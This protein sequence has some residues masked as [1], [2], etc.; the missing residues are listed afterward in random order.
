M[1]VN[2]KTIDLCILILYHVTLLYSLISSGYFQLIIC[3][4]LCRQSCH[5]RKKTVLFPPSPICIPF[6]SFSCIFCTMIFNRIL[7]MSGESEY[8]CYVTNLRGKASSFSS[9]CMIATGIF[10]DD[11]YQSEEILLY[12]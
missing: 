12:S 3:V 4:F 7:N 1:L 5:L 9:L 6:N 8:S 2:T 11:I 10:V